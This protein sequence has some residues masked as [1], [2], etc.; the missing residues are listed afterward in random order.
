M[1]KLKIE[2]K[3]KTFSYKKFFI[4][5]TSLFLA[6]IYISPLYVLITNSFKTQKGFFQ[7]VISLPNKETFT[8]ENYKNA[9]SKLNYVKSFS[10]SLYITIVSVALILL[11]S[12]MAAWILV[13]TDSK[14]SKIIFVSFS[15][16]I[17]IPF[18]STMLPLMM[19]SKKL[20]L[21]NP[22]GLILMYVGFGMSFSIFTIHGFIKNI[23]KELEEA[24]II[25]GCN[26]L[27]LFFRIVVPLLKVILISVA[28]L[29]IIWI[30]NDYLLPS[31]VLKNPEDKTL[32]LMTYNFFGEYSKKWDL[33]TAALFMC[34]IPVIVFYSLAQKYIISGITEGSI[35]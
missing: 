34:V 14:I 10:N 28:V 29:N 1:G 33:A 19:V 17:L 22:A 24:A 26:F 11:F 16:A 2:K 27:Q 15:I 5:L 23:P 30:W 7:S 35:K 13:R 21:L 20:N 32:P 4:V 18:Q 8:M 6:A 9:F 25:D 12:S 31:I 3:Y